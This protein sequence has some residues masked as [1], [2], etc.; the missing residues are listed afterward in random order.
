ME[1]VL[2]EAGVRRLPQSVKRVVLV[3]NK[4]S[5]G[6]RDQAGR[7]GGAH[8]VGRAGLAARRQK[9][10]R[11]RQASDEKATNPGDVLREL[12]NEYGAVPDP[13]R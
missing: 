7:H 11:A 6:N 9:G 2:A 10:F 5:P 1:R 8:A 13:D 4:I 12:F 3:G